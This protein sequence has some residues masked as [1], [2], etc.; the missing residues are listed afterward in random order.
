MGSISNLSNSINT[1]LH[2]NANFSPTL[3]TIVHSSQ[4]PQATVIVDSGATDIYLSADA[5]I[6]NVDR[7]APKVKV[8]TATG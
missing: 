6:V 2:H 4:N 3:I 8:G 7:S 1:I 5:L